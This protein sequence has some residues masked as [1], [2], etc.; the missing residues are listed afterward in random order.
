[1]RGG[2]R[3]CDGFFAIPARRDRIKTAEKSKNMAEKHGETSGFVRN[4]QKRNKGLFKNAQILVEI[5]CGWCYTVCEERWHCAVGFADS[6]PLERKYF[7][8]N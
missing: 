7:Y 1:M 5:W 4:V 3:K 8:K 2:M 6:V